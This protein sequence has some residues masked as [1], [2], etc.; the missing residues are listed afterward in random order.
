MVVQASDP[1]QQQLLLTAALQAAPNSCHG[2]A[3]TASSHVRLPHALPALQCFRGSG[4]SLDKLLVR[5]G[6]YNLAGAG[7]AFVE[8][9]VT[10]Y[11]VAEYYG[12]FRSLSTYINDV[13]LLY[14]SKDINTTRF[15]PITLAKSEL[16]GRPVAGLHALGGSGGGCLPRTGQAVPLQAATE[17]APLQA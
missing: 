11:T 17:W 3:A 5:L 9:N 13:M 14:L 6:S 7:D 1:E 12:S 4:S 15:A 10:S 16:G 8:F 2:S